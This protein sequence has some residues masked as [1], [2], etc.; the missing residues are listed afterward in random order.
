MK[1]TL[2]WLQ[3]FTPLSADLEGLCDLL[4]MAGLEVDGT[5]AVNAVAAQVSVARIVDVQRHPNSEHLTVCQ[6]ETG[7]GP[8]QVVC[9]APNAR[10]ELRCVY[11][12]PGAQM[13]NGIT[14]SETEIRGVKSSG[15]LCSAQELGFGDD[16][17]GLLEL[18]AD[19]ALGTPLAQLTSLL[20]Q[21]VEIGLTPNR[22]DCLS[23]LGVA[24][25]VSAISG[26]PLTIPTIAAV[27]TTVDT[28]LPIE[29]LAAEFC[30]RYV[31]RAICGVDASR[32]APLWM[33]ERLRRCGVR[34]VSVIVD[35]TNYVMLALGQ[36]MHAF[37]LNALRGGIRIRAG[38]AGETLELLDGTQL[39]LDESSFVI[40]D[41]AGAVALAGIMGGSASGVS[42]GTTDIY[43]ES[44]FF[45]PI[46][47]SKVARKHL[48]HSDAAHRFERGVD[49]AGQRRAME[50]ASA[51]VVSLCG[52]RA[53]PLTDQTVP[54]WQAQP[55]AISFRLAR[56]ERILGVHVTPELARQTFE[57]LGLGVV[58]E[59][60]E[61]V[62]TVP[63]CR[64]D[65]T[66]EIDLIEEIARLGIGYAALPQSRPHPEVGV[67]AARDKRVS[68][69]R[70]REQLVSAGYLEAVT[71]S[72]IT[73][74]MQ[75]AFAPDESAIALLNP[76]ASDMSTMR[77]SLLPGLLLALRHNQNRQV[78]SLKLFEVG[79][80]FRRQGGE[81]VQR[82][83]V[84]GVCAGSKLP[85]QWGEPPVPVDF[86]DIKQDVISLLKACGQHAT[87]VQ[88]ASHPGFHPGRT[89]AL[90]T[91][92]GLLGYVGE[93]H[94]KLVRA[95]DLREAPMMFEIALAPLLAAGAPAFAP[96]SKFPA[97]RRDI[98]LVLAEEIPAEQ[99]LG[100]AR[101]A[102]GELLRDLEL[103]DVYRGQGIDSDKKSLALGL[104]FQASSSTLT[105]SLVDAAIAQIVD[106]LRREIGATLRS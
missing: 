29:L 43:L 1:V 67:S 49:P 98:A 76:I 89:A 80:S 63:T 72:F 9:G 102:G 51:L 3:E 21:V 75:Q 26:T 28:T 8:T 54:G 45:E 17:S 65:L 82:N 105:D 33:R 19:T 46:P 91:E 52:G 36:P 10:A 53:G 95:L 73:A 79:M 5:E 38:I 74:E 41:H 20:D 12:A 2:D 70:L 106:S 57:R 71:Y 58:T 31:G 27:P 62:V 48:L 7:S 60:A 94:P 84:A 64:F 68:T 101:R 37:D 61:W 56:A 44:A 96:F 77:P 11:A 32:P 47:L 39:T 15:M 87:K 40:A 55:R 92:G 66:L 88:T 4:T 104:I 13:R 97:V 93:L 81:L 103:F 16:H 78:H 18:P 59:G 24:R 90:S 83:Y 42:Q 50:L 14:V 25:E 22:G 34:S 35:I 99:V 86:Y 23:V 85:E 30:P 69:Q 100:V 6:I